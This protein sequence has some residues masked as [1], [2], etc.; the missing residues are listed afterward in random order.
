MARTWSFNGNPLKTPSEVTW[1]EYDLST[2][3]TGRSLDGTAYKDIVSRK[4]EVTVVWWSLRDTGDFTTGDLLGIIRT[5][6]FG[7]LNYPDPES[8]TNV[9]RTVYVG[10]RECSMYQVKND[11]AEYKF[12]CTF[13]EQ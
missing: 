8:S 2:E 1:K 6:I 11:I 3:E 9:S 7:T 5:G 13:I 12:S 10:D 4:R